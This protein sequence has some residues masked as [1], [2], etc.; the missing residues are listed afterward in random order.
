[1]NCRELV[2]LLLE[3]LAGELKADC[4]EEIRRHL[5]HCPPCEAYFESYRITITLSKNLPCREMPDQFTEKLRVLL[6]SEQ[7]RAE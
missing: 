4:C 5:S 3:F 1:M 7:D 6:F 2:E